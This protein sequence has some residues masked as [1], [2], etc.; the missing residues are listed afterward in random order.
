MLLCRG[1]AV[2]VPLCSLHSCTVSRRVGDTWYTRLSAE[3]L[4]RLAV[5]L[6]RQYGVCNP[7]FVGPNIGNTT[8]VTRTIQCKEILEP[9]IQLWGRK[10]VP[11]RFN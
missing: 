2:A 9:M 7:S 11:L 8:E 1:V 5:E 6:V 10:F 3:K 4:G